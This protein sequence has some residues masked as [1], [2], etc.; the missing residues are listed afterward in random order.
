[1]SDKSAFFRPRSP[2]VQVSA[3]FPGLTAESFGSL[4]LPGVCPQQSPIISHRPHPLIGVGIEQMNRV[5]RDGK[6]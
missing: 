2:S 6:L 5:R 4:A 3:A 1:M